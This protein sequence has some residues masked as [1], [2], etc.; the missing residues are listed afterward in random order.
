MAKPFQLNKAT[1]A[2][3]ERRFASGVVERKYMQPYYTIKLKCFMI[4]ICAASALIIISVCVGAS[5][6]QEYLHGF[7]E[8]AKLAYPSALVICAVMLACGLFLLY[9]SFHFERYLFGRKK[10]DFDVLKQDMENSTVVTTQDMVVTPH[11]VLMFQRRILRMCTLIRLQDVV[12]CFENPVYG[13]VEDPVEYRLMIWD[14]HFNEHVIVMNASDLETGHQAWQLICD[15]L[16]WI[17]H[18]DRDYFIDLKMTRKGRKAIL[19]RVDSH[20]VDE[21][22]QDAAAKKKAVT[23]ES[24][25]NPESSLGIKDMIRGIGSRKKGKQ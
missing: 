2:P 11:Y 14:R 18:D 16:K 22:E 7:R 23:E 24:A 6:L 17:Y 13:T 8:S 12:A 3:G 1:A 20:L 9:K 19:N 25:Q 21:A 4:E 15:Q 10:E 5:V